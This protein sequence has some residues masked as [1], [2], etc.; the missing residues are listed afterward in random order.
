MFLIAGEGPERD[1]IMNFIET[2]GIGDNVKIYDYVSG[3]KKEEI[4][5]LSDVFISNSKVESF[6]VSV[7]EAI[8]HGLFVITTP[9]GIA[10]DA[11]KLFNNG[12]CI[13]VPIN[14]NDALQDGI[15]M[16]LNNKIKTEKV[17][18]KNYFEFKERFDVEPV[19]GKMKLI[20][21]EVLEG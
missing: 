21:E 5:L 13:I 20:Y 16:I 1:R 19:L 2:N 8:S 9:V 6:G 17:K 11:E 4:F 7:L 15:I 12:N 3:Q 10:S 18:R 14:D